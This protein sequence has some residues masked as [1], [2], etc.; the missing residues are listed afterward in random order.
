[1]SESPMSLG[2][3]ERIWIREC[4]RYRDGMVHIAGW[5]HEWDMTHDLPRLILRDGSGL[6]TVILNGIPDSAFMKLCR[7]TVLAVFGRVSREALE[8]EIV[9]PVLHVLSSVEE[10]PPGLGPDAIGTAGFLANRHPKRQALARLAAAAKTGFRSY[11]DSTGYVEIF[12]PKTVAQ[13]SEDRDA[14]LPINYLGRP[15]FLAQSPQFYKQIMIGVFSRVYETGTV[16]RMDRDATDR[17][18][19]E[20]TSLDFETGFISGLDDIVDTAVNALDSMLETM[21]LCCRMQ[22]FSANDV[23]WPSRA[24]VIPRLPFSEARHLVSEG[25]KPTGQARLSSAERD[26]LSRWAR[27]EYGSDFLV[28]TQL[29]KDS[30]PFYMSTALN[31]ADAFELHCR[32]QIIATGGQRLHAIED[33]LRAV[34]EA[35]LDET[36]LSG[37]LEA[38]RYGLPPHGGC[39]FGLERLLSSATRLGDPCHV[40]LFPRYREHLTP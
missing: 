38:F 21:Q 12:T 19:T 5:L 26:R 6:C 27:E 18:L 15:A 23:S 2:W 36:L 4:S 31:T 33:V 20:Y 10:I 35:G 29:P 24:N 22:M 30:V 34:E 3:P 13:V 40:G 28:V 8:T 9:D 17:E 32:G 25:C 16:F 1:M 37:Y 11:L 14:A 7:E 39:A